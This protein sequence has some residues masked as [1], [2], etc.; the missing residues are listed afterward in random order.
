MSYK[1]KF[2]YSISILLFPILL[3]L[4]SGPLELYNGNPLEFRFEF[5]DFFWGFLGAA[6]ILLI[7]GSLILASLPQK[8]NKYI[9]FFIFSFGILSYLQSMFLNRQLSTSDGSDMDWSS[10][11]NLTMINLIIWILLFAGLVI[12]LIL[13][14]EKWQKISSYLSLFLSAVLTISIITL[15]ISAPKT[16]DNGYQFDGT[17]QYDVAPNKNII[18]LVLDRYGNERFESVIQE[19]PEL[20]N[21]L[22]D[23]TYYD[24]T[25]SRYSNTFPSMPH[26][27]T[28]QLYDYD[29]TAEEWLSHIWES[30]STNNFYDL[31]HKNNFCVHLYSPDI[32]SLYGPGEKMLGKID[33]LVPITLRKDYRLIYTLLEKTVIYKYM[34]YILKPRFEVR[35]HV[36][37][38]M[39]IYDEHFNYG[40]AE[41]YQAL[42][43]NQLRI[44]KNLNN[45]LL[46]NHINGMHNPYNIDGYA[47]YLDNENDNFN[48]VAHGLHVIVNEYLSELKELGL[49]ESSTIIIT[50]DHGDYFN[51]GGIQPLYLIKLPNEEHNEMQTNSAPISHNDFIPT[52]LSLIGEDYSDYGTS[53]F[54]WKEGD[55]RPR[56]IDCHENSTYYTDRQELYRV[57]EEYHIVY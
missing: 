44:D 41:Y 49:Y 16:K 2:L 28:G 34:P 54:D 43:T 5:K 50:A 17:S 42:K 25:N 10:L 35:S 7:L 24:N 52:V 26:M 6:I 18:V 33:N 38:Q 15:I 19:Y 20:L 47:N 11:R 45:L 27:I 37:S 8:L 21:D 31:L 12:S 46:I 56:M 14:K 55:L 9:S 51:G 1:N 32:S 4:I 36:Y 48:E 22:Q 13:L 39:A 3:Y 57:T 30:E 29:M 53:I 23:F 40:N